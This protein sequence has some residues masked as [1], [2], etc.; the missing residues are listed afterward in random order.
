MQDIGGACKT[1]GM[2]PPQHP[3]LLCRAVLLR[4]NQRNGQSTHNVNYNQRIT[5][6]AIPMPDVVRCVHS[7]YCNHSTLVHDLKEISVDVGCMVHSLFIEL[8]VRK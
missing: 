3:P 7:S 5:C 2:V 6:L 4:Y 1:I 8:H